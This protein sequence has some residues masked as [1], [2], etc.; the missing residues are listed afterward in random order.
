VVT[1]AQGFILYNQ[2]CLNFC[3]IH[4]VAASNRKRS[5]AAAA[6]PYAMEVECLKIEYYYI[7]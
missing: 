1:A 4:S 3:C 2:V 6:G 5:S 7:I